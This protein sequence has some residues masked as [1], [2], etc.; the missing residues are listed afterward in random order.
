MGGLIAGG[1]VTAAQSPI[2]LATAV[3]ILA[4]VLQIAYL[5]VRGRKVDGMLWISLVVI[6]VMGGATIY[7][8]DETF[9]KWKPTI[10][11]WAFALVLLVAQFGFRKNLMRKV[12]EA[13]IQLPDRVWDRVG[14]A[15][16]GFL[17]AMGVLN[18][19]VAFVLFKSDTAAWV[20]FKLFG[21]TAIFFAFI[22]GQML[23]LS[24]H[25][26]EDA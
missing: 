7:F 11:Y 13:N 20:S 12:M 22:F 23:F 6:A 2:M 8:H 4:T 1:H 9:I 15:W 21:F 19:F 16:I 3:A 26:K 18:L 24:K 25:I 17:A 10:L 5:L 14:Y